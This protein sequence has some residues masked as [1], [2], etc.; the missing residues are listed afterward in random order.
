MGK[1]LSIAKWELYVSW[2]FFI[3]VGALGNAYFT[4]PAHAGVSDDAWAVRRSVEHIERMM[5]HHFK[6]V[7]WYVE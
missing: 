4:R 5:S 3:L 1:Q 6:S 7:G 2:V